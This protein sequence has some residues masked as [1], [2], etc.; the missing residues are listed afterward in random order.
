MPVAH[1]GD[2]ASV[3]TAWEELR[4]QR[5]MG[6]REG[7]KGWGLAY[8]RWHCSPSSPPPSWVTSGKRLHLSLSSFFI[9]QTGTTIFILEEFLLN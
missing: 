5:G 6:E 2:M 7:R 9:C 3:P 1:P 8:S 4:V